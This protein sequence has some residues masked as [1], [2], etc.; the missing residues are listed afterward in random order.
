MFC[1]VAVALCAQ[2]PPALKGFD[3][4]WLVRGEERAGKAEYA[5]THG[6]YSYLFVSAETRA[7]FAREPERYSIQMDGACARMGPAS[8]AGSAERW[9]VHAGRIYLFASDQCKAR[10]LR[11]P[12]SFLDPPEA[13]RE[14]SAEQAAEARRWWERARRAHGIT[15]AVTGYREQSSRATQNGVIVRTYRWGAPDTITEEFDYPHYGVYGDTVTAQGGVYFVK[16]KREEHRPSQHK[17]RGHE[18]WRHPLVLLLARYE[19]MWPA[20]ESGSVQEVGIERF[21]TAMFMGLDGKSGRV[22]HLRYR[23]RGP[24]MTLGEIV[25]TFGDWRSVHGVWTPFRRESTFD[26]KPWPERTRTLASVE[27]SAAR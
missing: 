22:V 7:E 19:A 24:E 26:G 1:C 20:R 21:G 3:P 9:A 5:L 8:G 14:V 13:P 11:E 23:G 15:S 10:F 12:D 2:E 16:G 18:L 27:L 4:V 6:Y 17:A 25:D